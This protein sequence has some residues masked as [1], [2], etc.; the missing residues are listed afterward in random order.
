MFK[1]MMIHDFILAQD[2]TETAIK[3]YRYHYNFHGAV[4]VDWSVMNRNSWAQIT[5]GGRSK[6]FHWLNNMNEMFR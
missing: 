5:A 3:L 4:R 1:L 6:L 2:A